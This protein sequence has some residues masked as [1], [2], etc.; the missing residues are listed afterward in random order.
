ML[1]PQQSP[2]REGDVTLP[3]G[4]SALK[5]GEGGDLTK[6]VGPIELR[7][8]GRDLRLLTLVRWTVAFA[9]W[10]IVI[11]AFGLSDGE[12]SIAKY[13][14]PTDFF[15]DATNEHLFVAC[16]GTDGYCENLRPDPAAQ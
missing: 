9:F 1:L 3:L 4:E 11:A 8:N 7:K 15:L 14:Q 16:S 2:E 10:S 5:A 6:C 13:R 12:I